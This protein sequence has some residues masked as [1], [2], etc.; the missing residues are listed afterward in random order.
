MCLL[1]PANVLCSYFDWRTHRRVFTKDERRRPLEFH[2]RAGLERSVPDGGHRVL[3]CTLVRDDENTEQGLEDIREVMIESVQIQAI[4][5]AVSA[6][7]LLM[8]Q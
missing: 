5:N 1:K 2:W 4:Y 3:A 8:C 7:T 6:K